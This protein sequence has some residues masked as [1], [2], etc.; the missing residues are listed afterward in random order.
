MVER[1]S[2]IVAVTW[3]SKGA[4]IT[5]PSLAS[6]I[7]QATIT[8]TNKHNVIKVVATQA[9]GVSRIKTIDLRTIDSE[10]TGNY[11]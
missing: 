5:N 8:S 3:S 4:S 1:E 9:D 2:S 11:N 10:S 7:A 6:N